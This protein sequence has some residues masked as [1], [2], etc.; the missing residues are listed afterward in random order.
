MTSGLGVADGEYERLVADQVVYWGRRLVRSGAAP[1]FTRITDAQSPTLAAG[2][3]PV[4]PVLRPA[5]P[6][7]QDNVE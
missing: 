7:I 1:A 3:P 6:R 2:S 4:S 5:T